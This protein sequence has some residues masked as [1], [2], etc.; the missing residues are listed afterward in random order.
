MSDTFE[1]T[2]RRLSFL[3]DETD[4]VKEFCLKQK[5]AHICL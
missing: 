2:L 5:N 1:S 3:E 4:P